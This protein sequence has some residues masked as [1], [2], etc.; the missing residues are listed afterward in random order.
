MRLA[1]LAKE[2]ARM[3][4]I[5]PLRIRVRAR[6]RRPMPALAALIAPADND[7]LNEKDA[8][9]CNIWGLRS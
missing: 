9:L 1:I 5:L 3:T 6:D 7:A 4:D 8:W 2:L